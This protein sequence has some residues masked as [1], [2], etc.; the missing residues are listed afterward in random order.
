MK[1]QETLL[2]QT[3]VKFINVLPGDSFL[4]LNGTYVKYINVLTNEIGAVNLQ[5]GE[6]WVFSDETLVVPMSLQVIGLEI[7]SSPIPNAP[8]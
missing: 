1:V 3:A 7:T 4:T 2:C 6:L 8:I 5:N